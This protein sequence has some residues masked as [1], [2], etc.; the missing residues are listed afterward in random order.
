MANN[1]NPGKVPI[2]VN[3]YFDPEAD[4]KETLGYLRRH[5]TSKTHQLITIDLSIARNLELYNV[6]GNN[7]TVVSIDPIGSPVNIRFNELDNPDIDLYFNPNFTESPFYRFWISNPAGLSG[8]KLVLLVGRQFRSLGRT[9]VDLV[10]N[11]TRPGVMLNPTEQLQFFTL[12]MTDKVSPPTPVP[13][14]ISPLASG[15]SAHLVNNNTGVAT[16]YTVPKGYALT[17]IEKRAYLSQ[18]VE[19]WFYFDSLL[20][21]CAG[22]N[23]GNIEEHESAIVADSTLDVD[24]TASSS[25]TVDII[26]YNNGSSTMKGQFEVAAILK[27]IRTPPFPSTKDSKCPFCGSINNVPV[28]TTNIICKNCSKLYVVFDTTITRRH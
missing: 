25:H 24:P 23:S 10:G 21:G 22:L 20:V 8:Q 2:S 17:F 5:P 16:P 4:F 6:Q 1:A 18:P 9:Q 27:A 19:A 14:V 26:I 15:G 12:V 3:D 11:Q 13:W 28:H 7:L